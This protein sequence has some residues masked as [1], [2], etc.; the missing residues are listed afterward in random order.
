MIHI[1]SQLLFHDSPDADNPAICRIPGDFDSVLG[2]AG[3]N[4]FILAHV[5]SYMTAVA[6]QITGFGFSQA[7]YPFACGPL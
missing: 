4:D 1:I 7:L 3:M 5:D 6:D 2:V